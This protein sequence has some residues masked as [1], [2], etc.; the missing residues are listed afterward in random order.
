[1]NSHES[2]QPLLDALPD[3]FPKEKDL[4]HSAIVGAMKV[5]RSFRFDKQ[6][7][8]DPWAFGPICNVISEVVPLAQPVP[9][10]GALSI[11]RVTDEALSVLQEQ[12]SVVPAV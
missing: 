7:V 4:P 5:A 9:H 3:W 1:M 6:Q 11:W 12:V 2:Q 8:N 10:K